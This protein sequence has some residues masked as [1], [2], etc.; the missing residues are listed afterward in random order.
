M[1]RVSVG[2]ALSA[3]RKLT[4]GRAAIAGSLSKTSFE[5]S[6]E[7][8]RSQKE[9]EK[10]SRKLLA[11]LSW[12]R[13]AGSIGLALLTGGSSL[14]VQ[15]AAAGLGSFAGSKVA[16]GLSRSDERI[17]KLGLVGERGKDFLADVRG[18]VLANALQDALTAGTFSK[19]GL[20]DEFPDI[21]KM[22]KDPV[23]KFSPKMITRG[24]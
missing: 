23:S 16:K 6:S 24:I 22:F 19:A 14:G 18:Q 11:D 2:K 1:P 8:I 17:A 13:L 20:F 7:K 9:L 5:L 3:S 15:M 12:G 4:K 21:L 10:E